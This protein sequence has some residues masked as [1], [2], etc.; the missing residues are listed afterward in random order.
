MDRK[1]LP[2][3]PGAG[4]SPSSGR[5]PARSGEDPDVRFLAENSDL[6]TRQARVLVGKHGHDRHKL[7]K[8][9]RR[10]KKAGT[11]LGHI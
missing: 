10:M 8:L 4:N 5:L 9:A 7:L 1:E 6:S 3:R 2:N 11:G